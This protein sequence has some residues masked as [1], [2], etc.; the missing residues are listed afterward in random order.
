MFR[1]GGYRTCQ[2]EA[3]GSVCTCCDGDGDMT[4]SDRPGGLAQRS[5][6]ITE[7]E[8]TMSSNEEKYQSP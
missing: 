7:F 3:K 5:N 2:L 4:T 6:C 8:K 1:C